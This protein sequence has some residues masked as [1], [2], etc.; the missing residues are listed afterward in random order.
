MIIELELGKKFE[1][2]HMM[3]GVVYS[4]SRCSP[5][6]RVTRDQHV[7]WEVGFVCLTSVKPVSAGNI[8]HFPVWSWSLETNH[9]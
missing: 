1:V 8:H 2:S 3:T 7:A 5:G 9:L 4:R 6:G